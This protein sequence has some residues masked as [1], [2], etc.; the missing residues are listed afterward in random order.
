MALS[1]PSSNTSWQAPLRGL[2]RPQEGQLTNTG[3]LEPRP[4]SA[5]QHVG[6]RPP[7]VTH[8]W[9]STSTHAMGH[10]F[11]PL[12]VPLWC[13]LKLQTQLHLPSLLVFLDSLHSPIQGKLQVARALPRH[14]VPEHHP[15]SLTDLRTPPEPPA[16]TA[17]PSLRAGPKSCS[18]SNPQ[19]LLPDFHRCRESLNVY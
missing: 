8:F 5:L 9:A 3:A 14:C 13:L 1:V 12:S 19:R 10:I 18:S 15:H 17:A 11:V 4:N 7:L 6:L 16:F 2:P